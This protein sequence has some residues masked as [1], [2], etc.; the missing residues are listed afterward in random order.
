MVRILELI[1][2]K[3]TQV[4]EREPAFL[5][6]KQRREQRLQGEF[7]D[8]VQIAKE[9]LDPLVDKILKTLLLMIKHN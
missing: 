5:S 4:E 1:Y 9:Y 7:N 6:P 3:T 8:A 2:Y